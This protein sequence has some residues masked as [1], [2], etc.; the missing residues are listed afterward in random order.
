MVCGRRRQATQDERI[1]SLSKR[2]REERLRR[3][4]PTSGAS[5]ANLEVLATTA[6]KGLLLRVRPRSGA[7]G[8]A[9]SLPD[10]F[11]ASTARGTGADLPTA[12]APTRVMTD[13]TKAR[14]VE[15]TT[16]VIQELG[17]QC[18]DGT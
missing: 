1:V 6:A 9:S 15:L 17:G 2:V 4:T 11:Q 16:R 5:Q 14:G 13:A 18:K 7:V 12:T 3:T 10:V 8:A